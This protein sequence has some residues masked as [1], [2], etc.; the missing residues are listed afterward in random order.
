MMHTDSM[1]SR[2]ALIAAA[3]AVIAIGPASASPSTGMD[4]WGLSAT[5][6][7][8]P[9]GWTLA[10][11]RGESLTLGRAHEGTVTLW[12]DAA[13]SPEHVQ[14]VHLHEAA[15]A[16]DLEELAD[17]DRQLWASTRGAN[18]AADWWLGDLSSPIRNWSTIPAED[19]A[20]SFAYCHMPTDAYWSS[21][22]A[23]PPSAEQCKLLRSMLN[24]E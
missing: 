3:A 11:E 7:A 2:A 12:P 18:P 19:F 20:E 6:I 21:S 4:E 17:A 14:W 15:H 22:V 1:T 23:G 9:P 5:G 10:I 8:L 16:W 13:D 24:M